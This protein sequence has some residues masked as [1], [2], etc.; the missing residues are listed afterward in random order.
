M[1]GF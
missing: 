1:S